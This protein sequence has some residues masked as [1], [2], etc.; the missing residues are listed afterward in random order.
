[1][2]EGAD[3]ESKG[4]EENDQGEDIKYRGVRKRPWGK[5]G[6]EIRDSN[7]K[8]ARLWL[9]TFSKAEAAARAYDKAAFEMRGP[10]AVLNFPD[11]YPPPFSF[12]S[13]SA[14]SSSFSSPLLRSSSL[15]RR[16]LLRS[17]SSPPL[18]P[19]PSPSSS[20][21]K[22]D[23]TG[24]TRQAEHGKEVIVFEYLDNQL[25]E[26]LLGFAEKNTK[27]TVTI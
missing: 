4:K 13:S 17:S 19:S 2:N 7:C 5:Y 1:M 12:S 21:V 3:K 24:K 18:L 9:G 26:D 22:G 23:I 25:L 10:F 6:A 20:L 11:E 27:E 14:S 8:G 15:P 16:P